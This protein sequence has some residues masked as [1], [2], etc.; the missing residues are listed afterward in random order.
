VIFY[1]ER[2]AAADH[3]AWLRRLSQSHDPSVA[4]MFRQQADDLAERL[5]PTKDKPQ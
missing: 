1:F 5:N 4:A 2:K 3:L